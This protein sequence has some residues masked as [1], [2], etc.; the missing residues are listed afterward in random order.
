MGQLVIV[1]PLKPGSRE[2][3]RRL[4]AQG[5]PI[6]LDETDFTRHEVHLSDDE[7]VFVF[8]SPTGPTLSLPAED[9]TLHRLAEEWEAIMDGQPRKAE[10]VF[11]WTR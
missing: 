9:P 8:E 1:V 11:A 4:I 3:A 5:P 7:A 2:E 6:A 10:T